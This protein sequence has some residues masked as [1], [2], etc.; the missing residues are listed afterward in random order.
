[1]TFDE[2]IKYGYDQNWCGPP[3]CE[4]HDGTPLS[5]SEEAAMGEG[6]D[7]CFHVVRLYDS[8]EMKQLVEEFH[9]P[10][11]WRASNRGLR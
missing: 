6:D 4:T 7:I 3:V 11:Q 10:S 8:P 5:E 1:V 9:S 2:W